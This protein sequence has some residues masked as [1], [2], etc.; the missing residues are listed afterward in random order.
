MDKR[1]LRAWRRAPRRDGVTNGRSSLLGV[2][3]ALNAFSFE[4]FGENFTVVRLPD[5]EVCIGDIAVEAGFEVTQPHVKCYRGGVGMAEPTTAALLASHRRPG[6]Y[7]LVVTTIERLSS[8][9]LRRC[10]TSVTCC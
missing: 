9:K 10:I 5:D 3:S 8:N 1:I 6:F 4:Q 2:T 7:L